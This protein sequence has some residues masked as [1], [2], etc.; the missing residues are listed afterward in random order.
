MTENIEKVEVV[1]NSETSGI[2]EL[3]ETADLFMELSKEMEAAGN[4][5]MAQYYAEK[6][7]EFTAEIEA[8]SN[9]R[10][11]AW[12]SYTASEWREMATKE[13]AKNGDSLNYKRY[14]ENA[15][16]A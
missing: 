2:E 10:L 9:P 16:K 12:A 4:Q 13:F 5:D 14:C 7:R 8:S 6:A 15:T 11:G 3:K 1:E